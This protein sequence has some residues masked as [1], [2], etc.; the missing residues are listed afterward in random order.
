MSLDA[1]LSIVIPTYNRAR[2]LPRAVASAAGHEIVIVDDC[3]TDDTE[4]VAARLVAEHGAVY[5]RMPS[6]RGPNPARNAGVRVA[7]G[8]VV[9]FLD[10]DDV[11]LAGGPRRI[12]EVAA[13][14]PHHELFLHN[15][16]WS[17]GSTSLPTADGEHEMTYTEWLTGRFAGELK[18]AARRSVFRKEAFDDT[19][20][21]GEGLLWGRIIRDH[22]AVVSLSPV[23]VYEVGHP[24]RLTS[25]GGLVAH[26]QA[27]AGIAVAWLALFG[28]D[29]RDVARP[30][31]RVRMAAAVLW[32]GLSRRRSLA[33]GLANDPRLTPFEH[34]GLRIMASAPP[35]AARTA[36]GVVDAL[37]WVRQTTEAGRASVA[38]ASRIPRR[39]GPR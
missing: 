26:A 34:V 11:L 37:R 20:A 9:F 36:M 38:R 30:R 31:W 4:Q 18:P 24:E 25:R 35:G 33:R 2:M 10:D 21:G 3:S 16:R 19:G 27:N 28:D 7:T 32:C 13:R 12:L 8:D 23:A 14:H 17:D 22:G 5:L 39:S 29:L 6:N 1:Q 15:C